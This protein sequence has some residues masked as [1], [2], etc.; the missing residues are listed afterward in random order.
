MS[1]LILKPAAKGFDA[2]LEGKAAEDALG[3]A[4][5]SALAGITD[6]V[7]K[8][9]IA[10]ELRKNFHLKALPVYYRHL[11]PVGTKDGALKRARLTDGLVNKGV[12]EFGKMTGS[13]AAGVAHAVA[14]S[15]KAG[16]GT[17]SDAPPVAV[18]NVKL[19]RRF[20]QRIISPQASKA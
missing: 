16:G 7:L 5:E 8:E 12:Q 14:N 11:I 18:S 6:V 2:L 17:P 19:A 9:S 3:A 1:K 13:T 15:V 20:A 4:L 10:K